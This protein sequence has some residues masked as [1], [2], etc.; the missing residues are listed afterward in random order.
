[1]PLFWSPKKTDYAGIFRIKQQ[2]ITTKRIYAVLSGDI[3]HIVRQ[4]FYG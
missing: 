1:M 3:P 4:Y 2:K